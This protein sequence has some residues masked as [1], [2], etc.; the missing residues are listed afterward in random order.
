M[1]GA[2]QFKQAAWNAD[3][4]TVKRYVEEGGD[5]NA[6]GNNGVGALVTFDIEILEYLYTHGADPAIMWDDGSPAIGFHAWEVSLESLKWFLDKGVSPALAHRATAENCLH[7]LC[8]KPRNLDQRLE[9]IKLV[10]E[11]G[12]DVNLKTSVGVETGSFMRDVCVVGETALHRAAAYQSQETIELLLNTGVD[13]TW[14]DDRGESALSWASRHWRDRKL[15][16][17]LQY[18]KYENSIR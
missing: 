13:K 15:L 7:S 17:L 18:G 8:A 4:Q 14:L 9:A 6:C 5:I 10:V 11:A 2:D 12:C 1:V 16:K 3:F